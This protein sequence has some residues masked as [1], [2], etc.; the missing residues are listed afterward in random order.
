MNRLQERY[1]TEM[2]KSL[3]DELGVKNAHRV[4]KL[5]KVVVSVGV[6][7]A[8]MDQKYLDNAVATLTK[9]TGQKPIIT[10]AR[11]SIAGFKL[12]EGQSIGAKVTLRGERMYDFLDRLIA[13]VLPRLR[14]FHGLSVK[15]FD[16]QGN[17][18]IGLAEQ[19]LFPEI[20]YED[21]QDEDQAELCIVNTCTVTNEGDSKSRQTIRRLARKNPGAKIVVMGCYATRAPQEVAALPGVSQVV[22]DKREL[23]DLSELTHAFSPALGVCCLS[24]WRTVSIR[25]WYTDSIACRIWARNFFCSSVSGPILWAMF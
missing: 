21:A 25:S 5:T 16:P 4:P 23:P 20:G 12:R 19:T 9:I 11:L 18:S 8:V 13:V 15:G 14:D 2:I 10:K 1:K 7:R 24:S 17:Y 3:T 22:T 6:G